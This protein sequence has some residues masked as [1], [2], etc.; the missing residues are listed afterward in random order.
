MDFLGYTLAYLLIGCLAI[1]FAMLAFALVVKFVGAVL[2]GIGN[3]IPT[4]GLR[5]YGGCGTRLKGRTYCDP[6]AVKYTAVQ[7]AKRAR[8]KKRS[9]LA[10]AKWMAQQRRA[11]RRAVQLTPKTGPVTVQKGQAYRP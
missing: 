6:C 11:H 1:W 3:A 5:C 9:Q 8:A 4:R 2:F 7:D 10:H